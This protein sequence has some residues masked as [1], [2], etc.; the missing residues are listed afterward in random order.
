MKLSSEDMQ[1]FIPH[2]YPFLMVD[3]ITEL[4]AEKR[5]VAVKRVSCDEP[6]FEGHFPEE[7]IMPGVLLTEAMAQTAIFLFYDKDQAAPIYYLASVKARFLTPVVPGDTIRI[8]AVP[9]KIVK[10]AGIVNAGAFVEEKKV[11]EAEFSFKARS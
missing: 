3:S 2:R 1:R 6:F 10:G 5:V 8:E 9:V 7:K 4:E 11:A